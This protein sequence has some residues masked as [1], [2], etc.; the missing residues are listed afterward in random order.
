M[1]VKKLLKSGVMKTTKDSLSGCIIIKNTDQCR[2][3]VEYTSVSS[4]A[5]IHYFAP[6]ASDHSDYSI[7]V[8]DKI[9]K[10]T[11]TFDYCTNLKGEPTN[12]LFKY[13]CPIAESQCCI[14]RFTDG[15]EIIIEPITDIKSRVC[16]LHNNRISEETTI[17]SDD[18]KEPVIG[19]TKEEDKKYPV[20]KPWCENLSLSYFINLHQME[21]GRVLFVSFSGDKVHKD[22]TIDYKTLSSVESG[23]FPI[24][25]KVDDSCIVKTWNAPPPHEIAR[26]MLL[27]I[28]YP[29]EELVEIGV[30]PLDGEV[31]AGTIY[32]I[33][34]LD[35]SVPE[36]VKT[37]EKETY[38]APLVKTEYSYIIPEVKPDVIVGISLVLPYAANL[39]TK[40]G[41]QIYKDEEEKMLCFTFSGFNVRKELLIDYETFNNLDTA[42]F[43]ENKKL[44]KGGVVRKLFI[45]YLNTMILLHY[46][47]EKERVILFG[48]MIGGANDGHVYWIKEFYLT[49]GEHS[50]CV[51]LKGKCEYDSKEKVPSSSTE[52]SSKHEFD[53]EH[54]VMIY[55]N[56]KEATLF[57]LFSGENS[58][59]HLSI[60]YDTLLSIE[61][62]GFEEQKFY[63]PDKVGYVTKMWYFPHLHQM[64]EFVVMMHYEPK[65]QRVRIYVNALGEKSYLISQL[66]I[67]TGD[68]GLSIIRK[69]KVALEKESIMI[70]TKHH[71]MMDPL[72]YDSVNTEKIAL[73]LMNIKRHTD[74]IEDF[75][76][77]GGPFSLLCSILFV[78]SIAEEEGQYTIEEGQ[79]LDDVI[80]Y[81]E[82][83][84]NQQEKGGSSA[85]NR[86]NW[87][88]KELTCDPRMSEI[89]T[90]IRKKGALLRETR[91]I[92]DMIHL[93]LD[94][95]G[96]TVIKPDMVL[97]G[98]MEHGKLA[99]YYRTENRADFIKVFV[100]LHYNFTIKKLE[101]DIKPSSLE[102][103]K[104]DKLKTSFPTLRNELLSALLRNKGDCGF[105]NGCSIHFISTHCYVGYMNLF[106][107]S[108]N[109]DMEAL[110]VL[111]HSTLDFGSKTIT[112]I[113]LTKE[114]LARTYLGDILDYSF[115]SNTVCI[116]EGV[117]IDF[118]IYHNGAKKRI[119]NTCYIPIPQKLHGTPAHDLCHLDKKV[120][121]LLI[122]DSSVNGGISE[123][124][125][126]FSLHFA[127]KSV[128]K[129]GTRIL[130]C[131]GYGDMKI[132]DIVQSMDFDINYSQ[133]AAKS[134]LYTESVKMAHKPELKPELIL[135]DMDFGRISV[136]YNTPV[137]DMKEVKISCF[138]SSCDSVF[139]FAYI[140]NVDVLDFGNPLL[141]ELMRIDNKLSLKLANKGEY[142]FEN[143]CSI[144]FI[145][146][147]T[148]NF[149]RLVVCC[150]DG[151]NRIL[152]ILTSHNGHSS[153]TYPLCKE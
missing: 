132:I 44:P 151:D 15:V 145:L 96:K 112:P 46:D 86:Y 121:S 5:N 12:P 42:G 57:F 125:T 108:G 78:N 84:L 72:S 91:S 30:Q 24:L 75:R 141:G 90:I 66:K 77:P 36:C 109:S 69:G 131:W 152:G 76:T 85:E 17:G 3:D 119:S 104:E 23:G 140:V 128:T 31:K 35:L 67:G 101:Y 52:W 8:T 106:I 127:I 39:G 73:K 2:Y 51:L 28:L 43:L 139:D 53:K 114:K 123:P 74:F 62:A 148:D 9:G 122:H 124:E 64:S 27:F 99:I 50:R 137:Y 4:A 138:I 98:T 54:R 6:V 88:K 79:D 19:A 26:V 111:D 58:Q 34:K 38:D 70:G 146:Q 80:Y 100:E 33:K 102:G 16:L 135:G 103:K 81:L 7:V 94:S 107:C 136:G 20:F 59:Q 60:D 49:K 95:K 14:L 65:N 29:K 149:I 130:L 89:F 153:I 147:K 41:I 40:H 25:K 55:N 45:A 11:K 22:A 61:T 82:Q 21:K 1:P 47:S 93:A 10:W 18:K 68:C 133:V 113:V 87:L 83:M 142:G 110:L 144:H 118:S 120:L 134:I 71:Y 13:L 92:E 32:I 105:T 117:R 150:G 126:G 97:L 129:T 48:K 116:S 115:Y 56:D 37:A 63:L 143:G